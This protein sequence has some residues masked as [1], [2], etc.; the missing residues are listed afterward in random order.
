MQERVQGHLNAMAM[1]LGE[2]QAQM[3]RLENVGDR[4][5][6]TA[7]LKPQELPLQASGY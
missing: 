3:L 4:L 5:A 6:K 1:R 2:L 7:G